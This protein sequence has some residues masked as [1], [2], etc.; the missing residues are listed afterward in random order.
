MSLIKSIATSALVFSAGTAAAENPVP[1]QRP[2]PTNY[3]ITPF[4]LIGETG[5]PIAIPAD[6]YTRLEI[7]GDPAKVERVVPYIKRKI[8]WRLTVGKRYTTNATLKAKAGRFVATVPLLT[9]DHESSS[10]KG[11]SFT[12]GAART[13]FDYPL[14]LVRGDGAADIGSFDFE[15]NASDGTTANAASLA[16]NVAEGFLKTVAPSSGLLT[17]LTEDQNRNVAGALDNAVSQ[18]FSSSVSERQSFDISLKA[19]KTYTIEVVGP[20]TEGSLRNIEK[21]VGKWTV[22]FATPRPSIFSDVL[23]CPTSGSKPLCK[24]DFSA[25]RSAAVEDARTRPMSVLDFK[26]FEGEQQLG[27]IASYLRQQTWWT[28]SVTAAQDAKA[29]AKLPELC[30]KIR[31]AIVSIGLN[32]LDGRI[33]AQSAVESDMVPG[34]IRDAAEKKAIPEITKD[35]TAR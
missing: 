33:V 14:F 1:D 27:T 23:I 19:G 31:A 6:T 17:T 8:F 4:S 29:P 26:L 16:L 18:L 25:A 28:D 2:E 24:G 34:N 30:R 7:T 11:E 32:D 15:V 10:K 21:R 12:R 3:S 5:D 35:C 20:G 22:S 13:S 9:M